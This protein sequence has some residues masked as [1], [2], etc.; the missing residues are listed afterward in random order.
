MPT[1]RRVLVVDDNRDT[2]ESIAELLRISGHDVHVAYDGLSAIATALS[3]RPE[4]VFLDI[5]LPGLDGYAVARRLRSEPGLESTRIIAVT[6]Y[7]TEADRQKGMEAGFDQ[8]LLK[9][10]DPAFLASL[11]GGYR[12]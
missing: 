8:H 5:G 12:E 1:P 7:G 4:F 3:I 6:G 10:V 2:A 9:P 11:L